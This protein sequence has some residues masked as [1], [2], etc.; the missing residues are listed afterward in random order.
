MKIKDTYSEY[1][2]VQ[3]GVLDGIWYEHRMGKIISVA[4]LNKRTSW[5]IVRDKTI[6][7]VVNLDIIERKS[8]NAPKISPV[9]MLSTSFESMFGNDK[10]SD[11]TLVTAD[12]EEIPVHKNVLASRSKV[13]EA[14]METQLKEGSEKKAL[15]DDIESKSLKEFLR[16]VYCGR[17]NEIEAVAV[18]LIYAAE[19]YG[20]SDLKPLCVQS[21][22][23][24]ISI[25]T[26]VETFILADLHQEKSL[27]K[28]ALDYI[29]WN[30]AEMKDHESWTKLSTTLYKE[31]LDFAATADKAGN[32]IKV[33]STITIAPPAQPAQ[34]RQVPPAQNR[35]VP[36]AQ[37][38]ANHA[39]IVNQAI[40]AIREGLQRMENNVGAARVVVNPPA[41]NQANLVDV[42]LNIIDVNP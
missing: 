8:E 2:K 21:L 22:V 32:Y 14:M 28:Y 16:F 10:Y 19:K 37:N 17:V 12:G 1:Q 31:I 4:D 33:S 30:Y 24:T 35:Q 18:D 40:G 42:H 7:V 27:K 9:S 3:K 6:E 34:N 39:N 23:R 26:A 41:P 38:V 20:L 15:I 29:L 36:L 13:F 5:R 25:D 11:Y